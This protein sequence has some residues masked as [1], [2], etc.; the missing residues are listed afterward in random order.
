MEIQKAKE[1]K[2][3]VYHTGNAGVAR[4]YDAG[5]TGFEE[6]FLR[7]YD[8]LHL[9]RF[10]SAALIR[11]HADKVYLFPVH[12]LDLEKGEV[13]EVL[14]A[15]DDEVRL[16]VDSV[17]NRILSSWLEESGPLI[18]KRDGSWWFA[19]MS[20]EDRMLSTEAVSAAFV[21]QLRTLPIICSPTG[22]DVPVGGTA[23][24]P[25]DMKEVWKDMGGSAG[26]KEE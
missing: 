16:P 5:L 14:K 21:S 17:T 19:K 13:G 7:V 2:V 12:I 8:I 15:L 20:E 24:L 4:V 11:P 25:E 10:A 9:S 26:E 3:E 6:N 18:E 22:M 1:E 23:F